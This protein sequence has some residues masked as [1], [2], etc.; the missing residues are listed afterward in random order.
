MGTLKSILVAVIVYIVTGRLLDALITG[1]STG[2]TLIVQIV[3]IVLALVAVWVAIK[4][5]GD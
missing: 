2:D 4:A 3:P 5:I 1:T